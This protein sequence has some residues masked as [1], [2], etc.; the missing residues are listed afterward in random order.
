MKTQI[1]NAQKQNPI[2]GI[3]KVPVVVHI[4]HTGEAVGEG[5]NITNQDVFDG[6]QYLNNYW[7]KVLGTNG[8][9][10]GVDM[11]IEFELAAVDPN[12]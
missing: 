1:A 7:R 4:M 9:A 8:D 10:D 5:S 3:Y 2:D 11:E 12:G 6:V